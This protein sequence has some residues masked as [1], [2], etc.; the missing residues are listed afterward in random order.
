MLTLFIQCRPIVSN[1]ATE[2]SIS[3]HND[4]GAYSRLY[5]SYIIFQFSS[6]MCILNYLLH[7][8]TTIKCM[9]KVGCQFITF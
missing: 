3:P 7:D 5:I 4:I 2:S 6:R 1:F 9:F 8:S